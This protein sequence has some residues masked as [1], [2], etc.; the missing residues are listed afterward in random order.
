MAVAS[1]KLNSQ[2]EDAKDKENSPKS[3]AKQCRPVALK[4]TDSITLNSKGHQPKSVA[5]RTT[6]CQKPR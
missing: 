1:A 2:S 5:L 6:G 3:L 4:L